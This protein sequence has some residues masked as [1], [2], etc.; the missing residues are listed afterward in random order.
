MTWDARAFLSAR[1]PQPRLV[2][3]SCNFGWGYLADRNALAS[4]VKNWIPVVCTG[5]IDTTH[6]LDAFKAGADGVLIL[7][8]PAGECHFQDGNIEAKK[9]VYFLHRLLD[10]YG[11]ERDRLRIE[12]SSDSDG[13]KLL[14]LVKDMKEK[15]AKLGP[16]KRVAAAS[17]LA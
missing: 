14:A 6:I 17:K 2:C 5:K 12:L 3:F 16:V 8:C 7:A 10:D 9:K 13:K 1:Y 15:V 4:Q 11:I